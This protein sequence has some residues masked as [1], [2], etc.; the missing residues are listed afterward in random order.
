MGNS[1][2]D[3]GD[4]LKGDGQR[5][6]GSGLLWSNLPKRAGK[7][8]LVVQRSMFVIGGERVAGQ[9]FARPASDLSSR[10]F[11]F[12]REKRVHRGDDEERQNQREEQATDD[13]DTH[14]DPAL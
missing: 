9:A 2:S 14:G 11:L 13:N 6:R 3:H 12:L 8:N 10:F 1:G 4:V 7:I 5:V